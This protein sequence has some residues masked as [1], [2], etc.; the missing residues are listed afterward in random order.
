MDRSCIGVVLFVVLVTV[1]PACAQTLAF[2]DQTLAAGVQNTHS[3]GIFAHSNYSSGAAAGDFNGDG[4]QDLYVPSDGVGG[5]AEHLFINDGSGAF[6]NQAAV[7]GLTASHMGKGPTVGDFNNDGWLDIYCTSAGAYPNPSVGQHRLY[8]NNGNGTFTNIAASAGVNF[9]TTASQDG[10][11]SCFGDYDL[12][13]DLDLFVS[14]TASG[15]TGSILFRNNGDETFTNV[16]AAA[17]LFVGVPFTMHGFAPR[18]LDMDGDH[19][20]ELLLVSDFGTSLYYHN[21]GNGTFTNASAAS[22][23]TLEENGMGQTVGDFDNDGLVDWYT[24]SIYQPSIS[25]TGNKLYRNLGNGTFQERSVAAGVFEG[26]YGWGAAA[27]DLDHDGW[28]DLVET[29]GGL[30]QFLNE[31]SYLWINNTDGTFTE[32]ALTVGLAHFGEGRGL[33]RIDH[34]NDGD[35]D[36]VICAFNGPMTLFRNDLAGPNTHWLRVFLSNGGSPDVAPHGVGATVR[37]FIGSQQQAR[38]IDSGDNFLS[39]NE[40]SAHFG[41][42]ATSVIDQVL[43]DWPNGVQTVLAD[44][45]ADQILT[46]VYSAAP[47]FLRGDVND[48]GAINISDPVSL[49]AGLFQG[50]AIPCASAGDA[51]ADSGLDIA[52]VVY[53]LGFSFNGGPPPPAPFPTCGAGASALSCAQ[54]C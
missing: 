45:P 15:N 30:G 40:L 10:F 29:N 26:G 35:Q 53:L 22:G 42:G 12:D 2:S 16:T 33:V 17:G 47:A 24:T 27:V 37:L 48:D 46:V 36:L 54:G 9:T 49:L 28:Q 39:K 21:N 7:W 1:A 52:D 4:W 3:V 43:I 5:D 23:T 13:G 51:N 19:Y 38:P 41:L 25:W 8:R 44:V 31:Q 20:P 50:S 14:G 11:G 34:D 32:Q 6:T 18:L